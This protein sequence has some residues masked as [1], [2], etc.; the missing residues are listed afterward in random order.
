MKYATLLGHQK[1]QTLME[2]FIRNVLKLLFNIF[3]SKNNLNI[4][5][6]EPVESHEYLKFY[7]DERIQNKK[8]NFHLFLFT[9]ALINYILCGDI[10][11]EYQHVAKVTPT[12]QP[13][14]HVSWS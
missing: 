3:S 14:C 9:H 10:F 5:A 12:C 2:S 13:R 1:M 7:F 11:F 4:C 6:L 8:L